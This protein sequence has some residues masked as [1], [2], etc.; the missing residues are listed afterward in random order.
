LIREIN[1]NMPI[2]LPIAGISVSLPLLVGAGGIV[3]FLSG[4]LG[5]GGGFL[6]TPLLIMMGIPPVVAV[7]SDSCQIVAGSSSGMAAHVRLGNVDFKMGAILLAG[8]LVGAAVG[9]ESIKIL[10]ALGDADFTIRLSFVLMLGSTG[11]FM[12]VN[13]VQNL[14]RGPMAFKQ[15][16]QSAAGKGLL[17]RLPMQ[18]DFPRS[19]VRHSIFVPFSLC[20][21]T[22]VL[23]SIMGVG[24]GFILVPMMVYLLAMPTHVAIGTS[25]F[26]ILFT[27]AG[28]TYMQATANQA[29]D[30]EL[31]VLL[32]LGSTIG[33]QVGV[34]AGQKMRGTQLMI[35]LA[36]LALAVM[37]KMAAGLILTPSNLLAPAAGH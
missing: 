23:T 13:S 33:A 3:G 17:S 16:R 20:V 19:G 34:R 29:V 32:A 8:G 36:V 1:R 5:V 24:G 21:A 18:I 12:L 11:S 30:L 28:A 6:L 22:G 26:Q 10:R 37:L 9:V 14:R 2:F 31:A 7:A 4:L 25:L 15:E 27:C 35:I